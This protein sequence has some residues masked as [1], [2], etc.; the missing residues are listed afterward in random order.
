MSRGDQLDLEEVTGFIR[1]L[2]TEQ[3]ELALLRQ[4]NAVSV[5]SKDRRDF[6][7][8]VDLEVEHNLKAAIRARFPDHGMSGEETE[9]ENTS[10]DYQWLIDPID[11]TKYYAAQS[12]LFTVS[13]GLHLR[14]EPVLGV[15]YGAASRQC[16]YAWQGG[17]AY[18]DGQRLQGST[19]GD[20]SKVIVN[21]DTPETHRLPPAE[22]A[23]FESKLLVL[24]R[25]VY[26]VRALGIGSLAACWM[27]SGALDAYVDLTG[28]VKPQDMAAGRM[29]LKESG[30]L[31]EDL[32]V[33]VGP[34][35]LLASSP[36]VFDDLRGLLVG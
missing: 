4:P 1:R 6:A 14:G 12:S 13:I 27:A 9:D 10:A 23:W 18:L 7:T 32:D 20:L 22:R 28:Y 25:N 31:M 5:V 33:G 24:T 34:S 19:R 17:G 8:Q 36:G 3:G 16:F 30:A 26:R 21:V 2:A 29:I 15:V 35:R 11:G